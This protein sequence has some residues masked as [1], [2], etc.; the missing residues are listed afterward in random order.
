MYVEIG[1]H[2]HALIPDFVLLPNNSGGHYSGFAVIEAKRSIASEKQLETVKGQARSYAKLLGA[3]Y[4][5]IASQES[6]WIT[7]VKDDY[8]KSIFEQSWEAL[9]EADMFYALEKIIGIRK[10]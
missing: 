5:V 9:S 4:S 2:N 10:R 8:S 7:S 3:E 6:L 1:N